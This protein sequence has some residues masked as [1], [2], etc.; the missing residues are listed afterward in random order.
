MDSLFAAVGHGGLKEGQVI[1]WLIEEFEKEEEYIRRKEFENLKASEANLDDL[2]NI[3]TDEPRKQKKKSG[4]TVKGVGDLAVRLSK[5]CN[6]VPGDNIIAY[7]TRGRGVS[8]HR[9]DCNNILN[10][11]KEEQKR[12][13]EAEWALPDAPD[14]M[15][16][17]AELSII[18]EDRMGLLA[19]ISA[20][21]NDSKIPVRGMIVHSDNQGGIVFRVTIEIS[22]SEQLDRIYRKLLDIPGVE[23]ISR[24]M[25]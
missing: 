11:N 20:M 6:P 12:L 4:I 10:L 5:C 15:T 14:G 1:N 7:T 21:L 9:V 2:I 18:C 25:N 22:S 16:F 17:R 19:D 13:I 3:D 8:I 23:E 24:V